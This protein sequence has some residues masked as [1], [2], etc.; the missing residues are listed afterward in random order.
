MEQPKHINNVIYK[1]QHNE[2]PELFY[3]GHTTC[4]NRR[5]QDHRKSSRR[6]PQQV[7]VTIRESGG[8]D[9][10]TMS[11]LEEF[12]CENKT[13]ALAREDQM[14]R[15]LNPPMNSRGA[16]MTNNAYAIV[17]RLWRENNKEKLNAKVECECGRIL[18]RRNMKRHLTS[19]IHQ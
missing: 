19:R 1:I 16:K 15:E 12:P 6:D 11:I 3:V 5:K 17:K 18:Y 8:W 7:Y 2:K 9:C 4:F 13:E 10:F 14:I